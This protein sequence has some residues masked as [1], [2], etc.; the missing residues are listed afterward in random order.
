MAPTHSLLLILEEL[1]SCKLVFVNVHMFILLSINVRAGNL[2]RIPDE[3]LLLLYFN[4]HALD[5]E[6]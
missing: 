3:Y 6:F 5:K 1:Y 4:A 2:P